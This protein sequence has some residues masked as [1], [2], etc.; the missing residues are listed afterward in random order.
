MSK[1]EKK[2]VLFGLNEDDSVEFAFTPFSLVH[3]LS[4]WYVA[5]M[6]NY[7]KFS[8]LTGF[9]SMNFIHLLYEIK[10]YYFMYH[11]DKGKN[12]SIY[13]N[14]LLNSFGDQL[15]AVLGAVVFYTLN[16]GRVTTGREFGINTFIF[17]LIN[18][19][20]WVVLWKTYKIG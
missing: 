1:L 20:S 7:L 4:G 18:I 3:V 16:K 13:N 6:F 9:M 19:L 17:G 5:M 11:T 10:D 8:N 12:G 15:S 14:S 2:R